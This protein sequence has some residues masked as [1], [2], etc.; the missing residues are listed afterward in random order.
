M[1]SYCNNLKAVDIPSSLP[2]LLLP[3][4]TVYLAS[5]HHSV[6]LKYMTGKPTGKAGL[7][8]NSRKR[9]GNRLR[10]H[11]IIGP[12]LSLPCSSDAECSSPPLYPSSLS[13]T[14]M[15][16]ELASHRL[17]SLEVCGASYL[18]RRFWQRVCIL[19]RRQLRAD[20]FQPLHTHR[21]MLFMAAE[22][23]A[24]STSH[25]K[26]ATFTHLTELLKQKLP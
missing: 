1:S 2:A 22:L 8:P 5:V 4:Q 26:V 10:P 18:A 19:R 11:D 15:I 20:S 24:G 3:V 21:V 16:G 23:T 13:L 12:K 17:R 25:V 7:P 9:L 6:I 14:L